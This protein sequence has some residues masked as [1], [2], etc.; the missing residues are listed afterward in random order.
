MA[1]TPIKTAEKIL[2]SAEKLFA[3]F[4][5]NEVSI[6]QI[7]DDAGVKLALVHYH[8]GSKEALYKALINRRIGKLSSDRLK[9]LAY[10][11]NLH[12]N[13]PIELK[14]IV[15]AF[16][17]PYLY[18]TLYGEEGWKSYGQIVARLLSSGSDLSLSILCEQ[19]DPCAEHFIV[20]LRKIFPN[21]NEQQIQWGVDFMVAAM[22]SIFAEV[23]RIKNLSKGLCS[24]DNKV[25]ACQYLFNFIIAGLE[26]VLKQPTHDFTSSFELLKTF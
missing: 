10:Y 18:N 24:I 8:F 19:F 5:Y 26:S 16:I 15:D 6:R 4:S 1:K 22:C 14:N 23:D 20:E 17:T 11:K 9:L 7:T 2:N 21:A 3:Q 13:Q 12:N 25:Q